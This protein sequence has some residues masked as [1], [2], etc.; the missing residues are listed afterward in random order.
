MSDPSREQRVT[1]SMH[2]GSCAAFA[3]ALAFS[4][5]YFSGRVGGLP[6]AG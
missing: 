1:D 5:Y 2:N 3:R 6:H 4:F